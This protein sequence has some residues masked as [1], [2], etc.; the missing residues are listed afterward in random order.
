[1][2]QESDDVLRTTR[3]NRRTL[4]CLTLGLAGVVGAGIPAARAALDEQVVVFHGFAEGRDRTGTAEIIGGRLANI[5]ELPFVRSGGE[6]SP[7]GTRIAYDTCRKGDRGLNVAR[8]DG[9]AMRRV[10]DLAGDYCVDVRWSRDGRQL[11]YNNPIDR[12]LHVVPLE[13]GVDTALTVTLGALGWHSW[14]PN[15]E[16]IVYESGRGGQ[17][18]LDIVD[19]AR[20]WTGPLVG[21]TQFGECEV[22]APDWSP[23]SDAIAFTSC[24]RELYV[25][26]RDGSE[27]T[28]V[29]AS[30][31]APRWSSDGASVLYLSGTTLV[32]VM[33]DGSA[34]QRLGKLPFSGGPFSVGPI[35]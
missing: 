25:V 4:L 10:V 7:D 18:R 17:R 3:V 35:R 29:A 33:L 31:Y 28:R 26:N 23:T 27:L 24:K 8:L 1:L 15:S 30:A 20:W 32:R 11:S 6:V 22:W 16:A 2:L 9:S 13:T 19:L 5:T 12:Q 34:P 14:S 21:P